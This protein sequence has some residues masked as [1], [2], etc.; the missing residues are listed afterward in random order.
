M[1]SEDVVPVFVSEHGRTCTYEL[2]VEHYL[3]RTRTRELGVDDDFR[4]FLGVE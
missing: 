2:Q 4:I 3:Y 1:S